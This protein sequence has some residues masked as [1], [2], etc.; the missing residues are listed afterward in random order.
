VLRPWFAEV[1]GQY[2][3]CL[4]PKA[5][6]RFQQLHLMFKVIALIRSPDLFAFH[7]AG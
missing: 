5:E 4:L 3:H 1:A 6:N 2:L 7:I